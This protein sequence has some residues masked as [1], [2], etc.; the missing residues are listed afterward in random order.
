VKEKFDAIVVGAGPAGCSCAYT[1]AK[2]G[3]S[4]LLIERGKFPGSKNMWG[5]VLYGPILSWLFPHFPKEAPVERPITRRKFS[6][7]AEEA[8]FTFEFSSKKFSSPPYL[9]YSLLRA[10]FD[11]WLAQ[12]AEKQGALLVAPLQADDL[13]WEGER[14]AGI[15]AGG[16]GFFSNVVIACDGVNSLLAEKAGLRGRLRPRFIK[17]GVKELIHLSKEKIEERF[18]L[19][20]EEGLAWEFVGTF[21]RGVKGG[22]FLYTNKETCSVGVV[23]GL[24]SLLE[25]K[26]TANEL[27]E[28][29]K[30][31]GSISKYIGDGKLIEY[32]AHLLPV[33]QKPFSQSFSRDGFLVAGDA[34]S[35]TFATGF[36]LEGANFALL[37]GIAA[38]EATIRAKK[39]GD[40][41]Q[42]TLS[43]YERLLKENP[44]FK[45][46]KTFKRAPHFLENQRLYSLYPP[47]LC[48]IA[49]RV[50][51]NEGKPRKKVSHL[52]R[53]SIK[54]KASLL[55]VLYDLWQMRRAL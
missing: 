27:L 49:E 30:K 25:N 31:H 19:S 52:F 26:V 11:R 24:K 53:E 32:S 48:E 29:F 22:A 8:E 41:S 16:E 42:K 38:A 55:E 44:L 46:F 17:Q 4:T 51:L 36:A 6:L 54:G 18:N 40:F 21:T 10:K 3:L 37:S 20:E 33:P 50:L 45:D 28:N 1:L 13:I 43:L 39:E 7:L 14:V 5:G 47:L 12:E 34:A 15:K 35:F 23:V 2:A 9:G